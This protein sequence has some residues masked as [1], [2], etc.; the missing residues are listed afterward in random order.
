MNTRPT[1]P[2]NEEH[3]EA[4][5]AEV[6]QR[7]AE[8]KAKM[9]PTEVARL[10]AIEECSAKLEAAGVPFQLWAASADGEPDRGERSGWWCFHKLSYASKANMDT[11]TDRVFEAQR[12]LLAQ[13]LNHQTLG[14]AIT[15]MVYNSKTGHPVSVHSRGEHQFL[16][17][18]P[19]PISAPTP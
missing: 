1:I 10:N 4:R 2:P 6:D 8:D 16:P 13:L 17:P 18:P 7:R 19:P 9:S 14:A 11:Y 12:S 3:F 5:Q 15:L